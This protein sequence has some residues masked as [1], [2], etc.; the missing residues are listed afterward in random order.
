[1]V[2]KSIP[3]HAGPHAASE[4]ATAGLVSGRSQG[5]NTYRLRGA[6]AVALTLLYGVPVFAQ[7]SDVHSYA[8]PSQSL[9]AALNQLALD[10]DRQILVPPDL[11]RGLSAPALNGSYSFDAALRRLLAG[12]GLTYGTTGTTVVIKRTPPVPPQK[13]QPTAATEKSAPTTLQAVQ[14]TGTNIQGVNNKTVSVTTYARADLDRS[15]VSTTQDF[16]RQLPQ[17]FTG[18]QNGL[19][20]DGQVGA[21]NNRFEN[22][23]ASSSVNLLG[24]GASSTLVLINGHR[25]AP[26]GFGVAVDV[27]LIPFA[28][29][30]HIDVLTDGASALYGSD[31]VA[32][33][34]NIVLR[35]DFDGAQTTVRYGAADG[36]VHRE[37]VLGQTYGK[38]WSTGSALATFQYQSAS[39]LAAQDRTATQA[40][41]EPTTIFPGYTTYSGTFNLT[42]DVGD[43]L[44][45]H[46]DVL[47]STKSIFQQLTTLG[48]PFE[49][50]TNHNHTSTLSVNGGADYQ[51]SDNWSARVDLTYSRQDTHQLLT[52]IFLGAP[53]LGADYRLPFTT[54]QAE[55]VVNGKLVTTPAGPIS[56]AAGG[57][58]RSDDFNAT[59]MQFGRDAAFHTS[60]TVA[61]AFGEVYVP[62]V[63]ASMDV[64]LIRQLDLSGAIRYDHYSDFGSTTNP[65]IGAHWSPVAGLD[66]HA[67]YGQSFRAPDT[68]EIGSSAFPPSLL[69]FPLVSPNGSGTTPTLIEQGGKPLGPERSKN[70]TFGVDYKPRS[71]PGLKASLNYY[72]IRYK[73][74]IITPT[75]DIL[76]L[77]EPNIYGP[78]ISSV[79]SDAAAQA[80]INAVIAQGG[81]FT[82]LIGKG[83]AGIRTLLDLRQLNAGSLRQ[84]GFN[85][86]LSYTHPLAGGDAL[87]D[88]NA[89][90]IDK[91]DVVFAPGSATTDLVDTF[92][93]PVKLRYRSDVGWSNKTWSFNAAL[94]YTGDY[95]NTAAIGTPGIPS[96][97]TVDL[98]ARL[99]LDAISQNAALSGATVSLTARNLF[100]KSPPFIV[101]SLT[102]VNYDA[103]NADPLGRIIALEFDKRW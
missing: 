1:M 11:V 53:S 22:Y 59:G 21:G 5:N 74:R 31:A 92:A 47:F 23:A 103:A 36:N 24:L 26:S 18:G 3:G 4:N 70:L 72:D 10:A 40:Q 96:W 73:D 81:Q 66:I 52:D 27:S 37:R 17:N 68:L 14:V 43:K 7:S 98:L 46:T 2:K 79:P 95:K 30:D 63:S 83:A 33:V 65:R 85:A 78:F 41:P 9:S 82:D 67:A 15:G 20:E 80:L 97:T 75:F 48:P 101:A 16:F 94:N 93:Q 39:P 77:T 54:W 8:L 64:P 88:L 44:S 32:G 55:A 71:V 62:L 61:A 28:A 100:N 91:I 99:N 86:N 51:L 34:V 84:S 19:S 60:R 49:S 42:Q 69:I 58:F 57:S 90:Y 87:I 56:V 25:V 12:S 13:P 76:A 6:L 29:I 38:S 102:Q 89:A 35:Q 45:L 50:Q